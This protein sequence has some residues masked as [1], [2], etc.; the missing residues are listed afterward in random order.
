MTRRDHS[1]IAALRVHEELHR[2]QRALV[3]A[4]LLRRGEATPEVRR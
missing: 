4:S 2:R 1:L 3:L